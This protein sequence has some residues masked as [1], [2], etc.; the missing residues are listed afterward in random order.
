MYFNSSPNI[1]QPLRPLKYPFSEGDYVI[2]KN[3]FKR[4]TLSEKVFSNVVF[5][6]K[7]TI[8]DK[9]R[10]D[11]LAEKYYGDPFYDWVILLT[12]NM[13]RGVYDWPLDS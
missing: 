8:Q 1:K 9:D 12:N 13:I 4:Y 11:L 6:K 5:F 7:Y 2:A 3:F 10:L